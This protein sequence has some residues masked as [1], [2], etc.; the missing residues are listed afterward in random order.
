MR[1]NLFYGLV[2]ALGVTSLA[3]VAAL[4]LATFHIE[5]PYMVLFLG[6]V[7]TVIIGGGVAGIFAVLLSALLTWFFFIPPLWSF[8]LPSAPYAITVVVFV[9]VGIAACRLYD[10]QRQTI[11]ELASANT[12]LRTKL[13]KIGRADLAR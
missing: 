5:A 2:V 7:A 13:C 3:A 4:Q 12:D 10:R 11:D 6:I 9:V 1:A 8:A